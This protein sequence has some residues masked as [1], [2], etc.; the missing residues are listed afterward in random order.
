MRT[1]IAI[2]IPDKQKKIIGEFQ[3][4]LKKTN[5]AVSWVRPENIHITLKFL[6]DVSANKQG[7]VIDA[8]NATGKLHSPFTVEINKKGAF[9]DVRKPRIIWT[10][11]GAGGEELRKIA[12]SLEANLSAKGFPE[13]RRPF[14]P[15]LTIGRVKGTRNIREV[16]SRLNELPF[17]AGSFTAGGIVIMKSDLK[18]S[19]AV[20][21]PIKKVTLSIHNNSS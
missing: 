15:H 5:A 4:D 11:T 7:D 20:Y 10:G 14:K 1:F 6:G 16:M 19:G 18:P 8:V 12:E 9:P 13:E 2:E 17:D 3:R 21:T